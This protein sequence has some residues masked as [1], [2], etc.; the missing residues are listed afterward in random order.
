ML[1]DSGG[2]DDFLNSLK[3]TNTEEEKETKPKK[4]GQSG[5][6][7]RKRRPPRVEFHA[8]LNLSDIIDAPEELPAVHE[9]P[10]PMKLRGPLESF[11][12]NMLNYFDVLTKGISSAFI[13]ELSLR[14]EESCDYNQMVSEF[15]KSLRREV[16]NLVDD[17]YKLCVTRT[18]SLNTVNQEFKELVLPVTQHTKAAEEDPRTLKLDVDATNASF[19]ETLSR[20]TGQMRS[21]REPQTGELA[22][23]TG[24]NQT[25]LEE[26]MAACEALK[27]MLEGRREILD[28]KMRRI[29]HKKERFREATCMADQKDGEDD[30]LEDLH[31]MIRQMREQHISSPAARLNDFITSAREKE[32]AICMS[33]FELVSRMENI[34]RCLGE[35]RRKKLVERENRMPNTGVQKPANF[36]AEVKSKL[37]S[38][39]RKRA[40]NR[41]PFSASH[42]Y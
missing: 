39:K 12:H 23:T 3:E 25:R 26:R 21:L 13:S 17:A 8:T 40:Q 5:K 20:M 19:L 27:I 35:I 4:K 32:D 38:V 10:V 9:E 31:A 42:F 37:E 2:L 36:V 15:S 6:G 11:E 41:F 14:L 1:E 24:E 7:P 29:E 28:R 30:A 22:D 34:A 16:D 33:S 18:P